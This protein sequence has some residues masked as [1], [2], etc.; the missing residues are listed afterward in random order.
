VFISLRLKRT[1]K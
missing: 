1:S